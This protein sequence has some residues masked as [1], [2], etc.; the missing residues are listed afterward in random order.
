MHRDILLDISMR[1]L[2][3]PQ[4][5]DRWLSPPVERAKRHGFPLLRVGEKRNVHRCRYSIFLRIRWSWSG[6]KGRIDHAQLAARNSGL[7]SWS[8]TKKFQE[9]CNR[10]RQNAL[11][12]CVLSLVL[13]SPDRCLLRPLL[14]HAKLPQQRRHVDVI[15]GAALD[16]RDCSG[17]A[18]VPQV[19]L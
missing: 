14:L 18:S 6:R 15:D 7:T 3:F 16:M 17:L 1:P 9:R 2:R 4:A 11:M 5:P 10:S 19:I 13:R 12:L 8:G